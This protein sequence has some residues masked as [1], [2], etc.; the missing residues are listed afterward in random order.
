MD[1]LTLGVG[2]LLGILGAGFG[3]VLEQVIAG[4]FRDRGLRR[5]LRAEIDENIRRIG[6]GTS[7]PSAIGRSAWDAARTISWPGSVLEVLAQAYAAGEQLNS[8]VAMTDAH[9][10]API[11]GDSVTK[12]AHREQQETLSRFAQKIGEGTREHFLQAKKACEKL[13]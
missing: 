12:T 6:D 10:A 5:A 8:W 2:F 13:T 4:H 7:A 9:Y 11:V 1:P 3:V